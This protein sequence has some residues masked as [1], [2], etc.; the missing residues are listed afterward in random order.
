MV[1]KAGD[2]VIPGNR[3]IPSP[4]VNE[5]LVKV[6]I[7]G[8]NPHDQLIR[9]HA[10]FVGDNIP[11]PLAID[12]VGTIFALGEHVKNFEVGDVVFGNGDPVSPNHMGTQEY[13]LLD[14]DFMARVPSSITL[15]E[16]TT[17]P[18][19][20]LTMYIA[21]FD[22]S[23]LAIPSPLTPAGQ[24]FDY[25]NISIAII[26]GSSNCGMLALQLAKWAGFG[27]VVAIANKKKTDLLH[28]Y[29]ATSVID[30]MLSDDFIESEVRKIVGDKLLH[31]CDAVNVTDQT[32]AVR[33]LSNTQKG[34][35]VPL[36]HRARMD[37]SKLSAKTSGYEI[38]KFVCRPVQ[39]RELA[40]T[41]W[42][43]FPGLVE[44]GVIKPTEFSVIKGL[45]EEKI[46]ETLNQYR[47]YQYPR[48]CNVHVSDV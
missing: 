37:E 12:I 30:R 34:I 19:N 23:T 24:K 26:G 25:S 28:E 3:P 27:T 41:F 20:A 6:L 8:L 48:R 10:Y 42:K 35:M 46:N 5:V 7:A 31:V 38:R 14:A 1:V 29:G 15:D 47:D 17:L 18:L 36:T 22:A 9:D 43:A 11:A 16:A 45:D 32:L 40:S 39:K 21:L 13:T 2:P 44:K 33:L 4:G